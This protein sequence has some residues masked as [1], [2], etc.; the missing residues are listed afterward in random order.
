MTASPKDTLVGVVL[1]SLFA[2]LLL[3]AVLL[4]EGYRV[5]QWLGRVGRGKAAGA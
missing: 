2:V 3:C 1:L 4:L 5:G